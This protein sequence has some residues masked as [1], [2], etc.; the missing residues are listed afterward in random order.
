MEQFLARVAC[1]YFK[2]RKLFLH[3]P[4]RVRLFYMALVEQSGDAAHVKYNVF[5]VYW[6]I[7]FVGICGNLALPVIINGYPFHVFALS[8]P[9]REAGGA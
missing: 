6:D 5:I 8:N 3:C 7:N 1:L 2:S 9:R 4:L